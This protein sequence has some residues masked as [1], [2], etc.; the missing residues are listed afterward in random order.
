VVFSANNE[1][2]LTMKN[3]AVYAGTFD[4][5]TYGHVDVLERALTIFDSIIVAIADSPTK[6]T[7]F[8]LE[9]RVALTQA[10]LKNHQQVT[11]TGFNC[12]LLD[13]AKQHGAKIILRGLRTVTDFDYEFQLSSMNRQLNPAVESLFLMPAE[14]YMSISSSLVREIASLGGE[15]S[16]FVPE[17]VVDA[18]KNKFGQ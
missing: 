17:L 14:K 6:K 12:L 4:P 16:A 5:I 15:V 18:L 8:S 9:E 11:V 1:I 13:F 2:G 3:I 7:L 10:V